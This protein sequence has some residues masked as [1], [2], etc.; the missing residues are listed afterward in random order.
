MAEYRDLG[1]YIMKLFDEL[2]ADSKEQMNESTKTF[3]REFP[4]KVRTSMTAM[5]GERFVREM[6]ERLIRINQDLLNQYAVSIAKKARSASKTQ[7]QTLEGSYEELKQQIAKKEEEVDGLQAKIQHSEQRNKILEEEKEETLK[8]LSQMNTTIGE[9]ES[10]LASTTE[11][12]NNQIAQLN[13]DWEAKFQQNQEE[14]DSYVKLKL[15][16]REVTEREVIS[17][18]DPSESE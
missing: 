2:I 7:A 8:Q 6:A 11:D 15:T 16:E 12:F 18:A 3:C 4:R 10:R 5:Q 14:W 17:A 1:Q 9:L 13:A